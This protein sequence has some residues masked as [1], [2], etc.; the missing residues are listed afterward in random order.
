MLSMDY[1][2]YQSKL[3]QISPFPKLLFALFTL[4][5]C[6]W[7]NS[8]AISLMILLLMEWVTVS[9]GGTP[10][11]LFLKF[12]LVPMSFLLIGVFSI[13]INIS[14][15]PEAFLFSVPVFGMYL[16][17]SSAGII[18]ALQLFFKAL[19]A[20]SC[21]Y[22]LSLSTPMVD[23]LAAL[24]RLKIPKLFIEMMSLIYRFIF[25]LLET[26][27]IMFTAQNSRLGYSSLSSGYRSLA[28]LVSTL[29]VRAYK[30]S[31]EIY[32]ALE[33]RGYDGELNVLE[34]KF[35]S[36]RYEYIVPLII[37]AILI[38]AAMILRYSQIKAEVIL[39]QIL[40]YFTGGF[41]G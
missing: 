27:N 23:L 10:L 40:F 20:V 34:M 36:P 11:S 3:K 16:G 33:A 7:A 8:I 2:A 35:D 5:V 41:R 39:L 26:A 6:L 31:E 14:G 13:G 29:F 19:G 18:N 1:Y 17:T 21:L 4:G 25:V 38:L 9:R 24:R 15:S 22:F 30:R 37:N 32:T 28:A 12:L